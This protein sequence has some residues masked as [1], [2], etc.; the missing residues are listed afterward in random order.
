MQ[1]ITLTDPPN[2]PQ[3]SMSRLNTRFRRWPLAFATRSSP[4]S[5][6]SS[7]RM[8][9]IKKAL[10]PCCGPTAI[11][12][13]I[14]YA[15]YVP[16]RVSFF[17]VQ[18]TK[19]AAGAAGLDLSFALPDPAPRQR[20]SPRSFHDGMTERRG[21]PSRDSMSHDRFFRDSRP[22]FIRP[23]NFTPIHPTHSSPRHNQLGL[24]V[25]RLASSTSGLSG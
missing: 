25:H 24:A 11:L 3:T 15:R 16:V 1:A 13:E 19:S 7:G 8:V 14:R 21:G 18:S 17:A 9:R 20:T 5:G 6:R 12:W 4:G 2:R 22:S 10:R 23:V